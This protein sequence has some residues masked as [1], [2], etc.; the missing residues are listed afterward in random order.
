MQRL[1]TGYVFRVAECDS[2]CKT[3]LQDTISLS[4][5][6]AEYVAMVEEEAQWLRGL[7]RT[8]GIVHDLVG[9]HCDSQR[10][11]HFA[12]ND[13]YRKRTKHIDVSF[14][15]LR[16]WVYD[17]KVIKLQ[18]ICSKGNPMNM[19]SKAISAEKFMASLYFLHVL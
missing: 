15:R 13:K 7:V 2:S 17:D 3:K 10:A 18:K 5:T 9:V 16:Q 19:M 14:H 6:K 1:L 4:T 12:M 8:F 11:I